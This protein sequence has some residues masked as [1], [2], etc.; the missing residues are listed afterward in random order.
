MTRI[1]IVGLGFMGRMHLG[2]WM[3]LPGCEV[4][5]VC[6]SN[7][8]LANRLDEQ[9]GNIEGLSKEVDMSQMTF[10]HDFEVMLQEARLDAISLTLP[11]HLHPA[12]TAR[13]FNAGVDVLCEKPMALTSEKCGEMLEAAQSTGRK[14]MIGHCIRFWPEYAWLKEIVQS[15]QYGKVLNVCFDR[16]ST[17]PTWSSGGWL[18]DP[19]KSGGMILDLHIHDTDFVH[20]LFG[21]PKSVSCRTLGIPEQ[22]DCVETDY[23][24][25]QDMLISARGSW[26]AS[27]SYGFRMAYEIHLEQATIIYDC[28]RDPALKV[29]PTGQEAFVPEIAK[30]DGYSRE[31]EWFYQWINGQSVEMVIT[32]EASLKSIRI[33]EAEKQSAQSGTAVTL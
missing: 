10:Y 14:L 26:L 5:A 15:C 20:Y 6:D 16:I 25:D 27:D 3:K 7:P 30:G 22:S 17:R 12:L 18:A 11:T 24:Y 29:Y 2:N 31:I 28:T 13:A 19:S 4:V 21:I 8:D 1:G 33:I 32:P 23:F 9:I